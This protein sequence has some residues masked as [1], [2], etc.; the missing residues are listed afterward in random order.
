MNLGKFSC[1]TSSL[2]CEACIESKQHRTVFPNEGGR[3]TTKPLKIVYSDGCGPM[4]FTLMG[5]ARYFV[6]FVNNFSRKVWLYVLE[7]KGDCFDKFKE[8]KALVK[9][10]SEYKIKTFLSDN[11]GELTFKAFN[12][13]LKDHGIK[14]QMSTSCTPQQNEVAERANRIIVKMVR[15]M[16]HA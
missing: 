3:Q 9:T 16:F 1:P 10:Q 4:R 14:K 7:S 8:F 5:G 13:F 15:S 2:L 6:T 11:G 12:N